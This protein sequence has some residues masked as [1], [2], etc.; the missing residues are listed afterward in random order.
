MPSNYTNMHTA[1]R[2]IVPTAPELFVTLMGPLEPDLLLSTDERET[3]Y[4][5][6]TSAEHDQRM[7]RYEA[8]FQQYR[9][10]RTEALYDLRRQADTF[11]RT[12]FAQAEEHLS[13]Q[14]QETLRQLEVEMS[15]RST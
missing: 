7:Q 11:V 14:E 15:Q 13:A 3:K 12:L 1:K 9:I 6:E 2:P 5:G 4:A 8:A 10:K